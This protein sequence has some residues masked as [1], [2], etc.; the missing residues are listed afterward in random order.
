MENKLFNIIFV[1][2]ISICKHSKNNCS[3]K[4]KRAGALG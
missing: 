1:D 3:I 2:E 4:Y